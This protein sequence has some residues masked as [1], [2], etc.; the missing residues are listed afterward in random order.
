MKVKAVN[1]IGTKKE[2]IHGQ[3]VTVKMYDSIMEPSFNYEKSVSAV[4]E[5]RPDELEKLKDDFDEYLRRKDEYENGR[6]VDEDENIDWVDCSPA[7][8]IIWKEKQ[9]LMDGDENTDS[10]V[11]LNKYGNPI[12]VDTFFNRRK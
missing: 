2:I 3:E 8:K 9:R 11:P 10:D 4:L 7:D 6:Y 1:F 12:C 5:A